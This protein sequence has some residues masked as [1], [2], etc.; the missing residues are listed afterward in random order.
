MTSCGAAVN[1][2]IAT[3]L[4]L[5]QCSLL[6]ILFCTASGKEDRDHYC[7]RGLDCL[8]DQLISFLVPQV[9]IQSSNPTQPDVMSVGEGVLNGSGY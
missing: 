5:G 8:F 4:P 2:I 6:E 7:L 3:T 1:G 9:L